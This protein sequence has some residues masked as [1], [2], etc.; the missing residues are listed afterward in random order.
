MICIYILSRDPFFLNLI[1]SIS[2][3][4][5]SPSIFLDKP[6]KT[7]CSP[8]I[9]EHGLNRTVLKAQLNNQCPKLSRYATKLFLAVQNALYSLYTHWLTLINIQGKNVTHSVITT[10]IS[11][12]AI[13]L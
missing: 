6:E 1:F 2:L 4:A 3:R 9:T 7:V 5:E 10:L 8:G 13:F 11:S 12:L